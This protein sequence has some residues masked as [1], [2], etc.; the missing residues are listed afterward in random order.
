MGR[1]RRPGTRPLRG[2]V[3]APGSG[4]ITTPG[5][6]QCRRPVLLDAARPMGRGSRCASR[7]DAVPTPSSARRPSRRRGRPPGRQLRETPGLVVRNY[8]PTAR[9]GE[10]EGPGWKGLVEGT[11]PRSA[12]WIAGGQADPSGRVVAGTKVRWPEYVARLPCDG[13]G[14][15]GTP[16][17]AEVLEDL[18]LRPA[19]VKP[20][21]GGRGGSRLHGAWSGVLPATWDRLPAS[22][23]GSSPRAR[24]PG[25][26]GQVP[27]PGLMA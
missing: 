8:S 24:H 23:R 12:D 19:E 14:P 4:A 11:M 5:R 3:P 13:R 22:I 10:R 1:L 25:D 27:W 6:G 9:P 26:R 15:H 21:T 20:A 7:T 18:S 16:G 17:I 2:S